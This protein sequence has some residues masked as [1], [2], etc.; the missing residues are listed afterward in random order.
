MEKQNKNHMME[1]NTVRN[2]I[3]QAKKRLKKNNY[4]KMNR[5]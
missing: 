2:T 1:N 3:L 5:K 4:D